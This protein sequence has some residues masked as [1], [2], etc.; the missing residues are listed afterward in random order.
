MQ[1]HLHERELAV[2]FDDPAEA[3]EVVLFAD[4][5]LRMLDRSRQRE[6]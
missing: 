4:L 3:V 5:L 2:D 1:D 6:S